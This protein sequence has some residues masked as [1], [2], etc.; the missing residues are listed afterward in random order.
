VQQAADFQQAVEAEAA[1]AAAAAAQQQ[2]GRPTSPSGRS[3]SR[4][5]SVDVTGDDLPGGG[6]VSGRGFGAGSGGARG[7]SAKQV[8]A[9]RQEVRMAQVAGAGRVRQCDSVRHDV[10]Y[11][12]GGGVG[13]DRCVQVS[14]LGMAARWTVCL[15]CWMAMMGSKAKRMYRGVLDGREMD[16]RCRCRYLWV[17]V[18]GRASLRQLLCFSLPNQQPG[19]LPNQQLAV[20]NTRSPRP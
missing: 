11:I 19:N 8:T 9:L 16:C 20:L 18:R 2:Q 15:R 4:S 12:W 3:R 14:M 17:G 6:A 13:E 10:L 7:A 5:S 1:A